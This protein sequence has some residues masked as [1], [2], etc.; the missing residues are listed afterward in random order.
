[1]ISGN[2]VV[3]RPK[4]MADAREDYAW[5][6]DPGLTE[7]DA[8]PLLTMSFG[9]YLTEHSWELKFPAPSRRQF[10]VDA[11]DGRH[12]GNCAYYDIDGNRGQAEL[13]V[14]IG[15]REYW[16]RGYGTDTVATLLGHIFSDTKLDRLYLKTLENNV[17][18]QKCFAKS[19]FRAY[20]HMARD[21]YSFLLMDIRRKDWGKRRALE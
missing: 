4:T 19:G 5:Q 2:L 13:G 11:L 12:I 3:L 15:D 18:A 17:R 8:A 6:T 21:G 14:M 9:Q 16:G 1:M 20:G 10:S 7:L